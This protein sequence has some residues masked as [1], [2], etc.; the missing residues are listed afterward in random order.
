MGAVEK[1]RIVM[2]C[3]EAQSHITEFINDKLDMTKMEEFLSHVNQCSE[4]RE[5]LE[6]YYALLT[7]MKLL[8]EDKELSDHFNQELERKLKFSADKIRKIKIA[9]VRRK[10]YLMMVTLGFVIVSSITVTK[11]ILIPKIP[12]KP[13][14]NLGYSGVPSY[15][16][17]I[18]KFIREYDQEAKKY[19]DVRREVRIMLYQNQ[20]KYRFRKSLPAYK[21]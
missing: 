5:E 21:K 7:A 3:M 8:D 16:S 19:T 11:A 17:P 1:G 15:L 10:F 9:R 14:F 4:C 13:S 18:K 2:N 6:V 20:I 12:P